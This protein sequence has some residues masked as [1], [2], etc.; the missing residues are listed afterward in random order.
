VAET[1]KPDVSTTRE[2]MI[3]AATALFRER[4]YD[5]TGFREIVAVA[6]AAHGAI[7]H[8]F[9]GGKEEIGAITAERAGDSLARTIREV[10]ATQDPRS[11]VRTL[12]GVVDRVLIRTG[13]RPGCPVS[14][15]ALAADDP[16]GL[17]RQAADHAYRS[18]IEPL[19]QCL[20]RHGVEG[21]RANAYATMAVAAV[22]GAVLLCRA[23]GD[24]GPLGRVGAGLLAALPE[25]A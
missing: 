14:A 19:Q 2:R 21:G 20:E 1:N 11:T 15:A 16:D 24:G 25:G 6:G 17:L 12:I 4:G 8:H 10:A 3:A 22:E 23:S 18:W 13:H 9:P 7:Y 5:G